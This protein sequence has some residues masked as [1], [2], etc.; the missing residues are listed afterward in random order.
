MNNLMDQ[1]MDGL[2]WTEEKAE[3][4]GKLAKLLKQCVEIYSK[5]TGTQLV[6]NSPS[7]AAAETAELDTFLQQMAMQWSRLP[8]NSRHELV[9]PIRTKANNNEALFIKEIFSQL[10]LL[11]SMTQPVTSLGVMIGQVVK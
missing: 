9:D 11:A 3:S 2:V 4:V 10:L 5:Q 1:L 8:K 7:K 6:S